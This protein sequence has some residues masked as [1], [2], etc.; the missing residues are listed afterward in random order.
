MELNRTRAV[1][2]AKSAENSPLPVPRKFSSFTL[3]ANMQDMPIP[4][5]LIIALVF[6]CIIVVGLIE[7]V[8][9]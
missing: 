4:T 5:A 8:P 2:N 6:A 9:L 7:E 1:M 3:E